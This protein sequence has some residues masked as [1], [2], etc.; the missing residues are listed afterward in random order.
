[1]RECFRVPRVMYILSCGPRCCHGLCRTFHFVTTQKGARERR[2]VGRIASL[3]EE[4]VS[5]GLGYQRTMP[6][7]K[8]IKW[9]R[10]H[11][12]IQCLSFHPSINHDFILL[13]LKVPFILRGIGPQ[14][15]SRTHCPEKHP[16]GFNCSRPEVVK[17]RRNSAPRETVVYNASPCRVRREFLAVVLE[18]Y[19]QQYK[20]RVVAIKLPLFLYVLVLRLANSFSL[21]IIKFTTSSKYIIV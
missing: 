14:D 20:D 10:S 21:Y 17:Q 8:R 16:H 7:S 15:L 13:L 18:V 6:S 5:S 3:I 2:L 11:L 4:S 19:S 1:M 9:R 12:S